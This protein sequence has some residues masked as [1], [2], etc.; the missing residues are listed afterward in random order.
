MKSKDGII[1]MAVGEAMGIPVD[2]IERDKMLENPVLEMKEYGTF[3]K[4]IGTWSSD[5]ALCF[6]EELGLGSAFGFFST[7]TGVAKSCLLQ[8]ATLSTT[9]FA[10][11]TLKFTMQRSN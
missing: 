4:P 2:F 6:G 9:S 1:G 3:N 11:S 7:G 10:F 5:T 8:T